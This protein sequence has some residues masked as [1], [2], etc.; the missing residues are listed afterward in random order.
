MIY[1]YDGSLKNESGT[2]ILNSL[3]PAD[4]LTD[5]F[6]QKYVIAEAIS[7]RGCDTIRKNETENCYRPEIYKNFNEPKSSFYDCEKEF[8]DT[9][10]Q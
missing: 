8:E 4:I 9:G 7:C 1:K 10:M 5:V 6:S 3:T 2:G